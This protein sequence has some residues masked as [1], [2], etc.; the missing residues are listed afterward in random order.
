MTRRLPARRRF[1]RPQWAISIAI[2]LMVI[3]F[4]G[5]AQWNSS[6]DRQEFITSAQRVLIVEAEQEQ[7]EQE[8][9]R[10]QVEEAENQLRDLQAQSEGSRSAQ[11]ELNRQLSVARLVA[12]TSEVRGP[13]MVIEIADSLGPIPDDA[14]TSDYFVLTDDVRDIVTALWA[15]GAEAIAIS[16][17]GSAPERLVSTTSIYGVGSAILVNI[18]PLS[19]PFRIEAIGPEGL[20]DRFLSHPI[21]LT[22]L[23]ERIKAYALQFASEPRDEIIL[24]DFIGNTRLRYGAPVAEVD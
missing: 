21:Y 10:A 12:G 24:P 22:R 18:A 14:R 16:G 1:S 2:A 13:G 6:L 9:L 5:A 23:A 3:G 15:S 4:I 7:R 20:R 19:P 8:S 11:A 17:G